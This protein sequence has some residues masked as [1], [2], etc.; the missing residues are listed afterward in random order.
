MQSLRAELVQ[1]G[2]VVLDSS[3]GLRK[4][5]GGCELRHP[6][7]AG[8]ETENWSPDHGG[9]REARL[10]VRAQ[11]REGGVEKPDRWR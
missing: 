1:S 2:H 11:H 3:L 7:T 4:C 9:G 6:V 8:E 5:F 10:C